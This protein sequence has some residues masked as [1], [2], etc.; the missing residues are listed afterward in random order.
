[1]PRHVSWAASNWIP[2][3]LMFLWFTIACG[4]MEDCACLPHSHSQWCEFT[5]GEEN[6]TSRFRAVNDLTVKKAK[7]HQS[8]YGD[9]QAQAS[10]HASHLYLMPCSSRTQCICQR[11]D[12]FIK[13]VDGFGMTGF[14]SC[15]KM[16]RLSSMSH[17]RTKVL[18]SNRTQNPKA[19]ETTVGF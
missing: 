19:C 5:P 15:A 3:E 11:V 12:G 7:G 17:A 8:S 14:P 1:M 4:A 10:Q 18:E 2:P 6:R 13:R 9:P 16:G